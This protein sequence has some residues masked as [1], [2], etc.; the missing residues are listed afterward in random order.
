MWSIAVQPDRAAVEDA[1]LMLAHTRVRAPIA[2]KTGRILVTRGNLA[3]ANTTELVLINRL[4]PTEVAFAVPAEHLAEIRRRMGQEPLRVAAT[5]SGATEPA[6]GRLTFVD[7]RVD[8]RTGTVALQATFTN[9]DARLWPG[10]FVNVELTLGVEPGA[11]VVP[12]AAVQSGQQGSYVFVVRSNGTVE[13]RPVRFARQVGDDVVLAGGVGEGETVVLTTFLG[14]A[15]QFQESIRDT[16]ALLVLA[17]AVIY[18]I[19]GVLYESFVHPVTILSGLPAAAVG[20]LLTLI[21][22]GRDLDI[23]GLVG[24]ILLIGIVKKNAIM[25][26]DFALEAQHGDRSSEE[27]IREAALVRFRPITMTTLAAMAGALPIALGL[28]AG[29]EARQPLGLTVVGGLLLSQ[30]VT[31]YLTPVLFVGLGGLAARLA[32]WSPRPA[33]RRRAA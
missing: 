26:I 1:R 22:F 11:L 33:W 24:I 23:Y 3:E 16:L 17:V 12:A 28:G 7:N 19:L 30:L 8:P 29:G 9:E 10:Q 31:L 15:E 20:A 5:P 13:S 4:R 32:R 27:A 14:L 18:L 2:G 6:L 21:L 25:M